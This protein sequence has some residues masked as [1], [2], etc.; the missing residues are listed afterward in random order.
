[1]KPE[2]YSERSSM[3]NFLADDGEQVIPV[4]VKAKENLKAKSLKTYRDNLI[5]HTTSIPQNQLFLKIG[6]YFSL[7]T[8]YTAGQSSGLPCGVGSTA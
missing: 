7:A 2:R 5:N 4:E 3:P 6:A 1:M 8:E